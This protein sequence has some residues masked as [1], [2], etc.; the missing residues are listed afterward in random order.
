MRLNQGFQSLI[1]REFPFSHLTNE[2]RLDPRERASREFDTQVA[3][4]LRRLGF[5]VHPKVL[6]NIARRVGYEVDLLCLSSEIT[7]VDRD[8]PQARV[9]WVMTKL[10]RGRGLVKKSVLLQIWGAFTCML[11][12]DYDQSFGPDSIWVVTDG[13]FSEEAW[14]LVMAIN[15]GLGRELF[16]LI[17]G[18][19]L[20]RLMSR[21]EPPDGT[22]GHDTR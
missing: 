20:K 21:S 17:D 4:M 10:R 15:E 6:V 11:Y 9:V 19:K 7:K 2:N 22:I 5:E 13:K 8:I 3:Q 12:K 16:V 18:D 1:R 14:D